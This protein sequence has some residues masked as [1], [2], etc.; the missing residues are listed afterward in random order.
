[1]TAVPKTVSPNAIAREYWGSNLP[2]WIKRLAEECERS[3]QSAVAKRISRSPS[4]VNMVLKNRY[5]G[6]LSDVKDRFEAAFQESGVDCPILGEI[7]GSQCLKT[8]ALPY[9][10]GNHVAVRLF[11]AC[12]GCPHNLKKCGGRDA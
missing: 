6:N 11:V 2:A 1:M 10:G 8:Q 4:L 12:K 3:S 5:P 7:T 9:N